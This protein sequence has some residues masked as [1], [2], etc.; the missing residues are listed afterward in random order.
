MNIFA[1][2]V[3][4]TLP[5]LPLFLASPRPSSQAGTSHIET[6][7]LT[8]Y[9]QPISGWKG[10]QGSIL[11][12]PQSQLEPSCESSR[13]GTKTKTKLNPPQWLGLWVPCVNLQESKSQTWACKL[14]WGSHKK[15]KKKVV[16]VE[17]K[18]V[19]VHQTIRHGARGGRE[20]ETDSFE[21]VYV[22]F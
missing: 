17:V 1:D 21:C 3:P 8:D 19:C 5:P 4:V 13:K 6:N 18:Q 16:G 10:L 11:C 12:L 14:P 20:P 2:A 9:P 22:C 15:E 7:A